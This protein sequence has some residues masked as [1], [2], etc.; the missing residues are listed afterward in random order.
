[1]RTLSTAI[2]IAPTAVGTTLFDRLRAMAV[3]LR[4][5]I[6]VIDMPDNDSVTYPT[7]T[8]D[9]APSWTSE[10]S[11]ITPGDP[12]FST[13]TATPR[14]LAHLVQL[15]NEVIDDSDPDALEVLNQHLL[16]VL[17]V[18]LDAGLLEGSG[19]APEVRGLKN[20][21]GIQT[22]AAATNGQQPTFDNFSDAIALLEGI[23]I[24]PETIRVVMHTRNVSTLRKIKASTAGTYLWGDPSQASARPVWGKNWLATTQLST[25]EVQG[26]SGSVCNSAYIF[27][28]PEVIFVRRQDPQLVVD[29]SRLFNSDQSEVRVTQR[30][31]LI[32]PN[33]TAIVRLTGLLP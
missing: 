4:S 17:A 21:A 25:N 29:R 27:S 6:R 3:V 16:R 14:K 32:V 28:A 20:V 23:N 26:T 11:A 18:K 12:T 19:S 15:N 33:P 5:G 8:G 1:M 30:L 2:S 24:D 9:V 7:I 31:D 13:V 10:G 22:L